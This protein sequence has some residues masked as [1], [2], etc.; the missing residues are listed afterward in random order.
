[1]ADSKISAL[2]A[3]S[4][5]TGADIPIVQSGANKKAGIALFTPAAIGAA[6]AAQGTKADSALQPADLYPAISTANISSGALATPRDGKRYV[7]QLSADVTDWT[8][9]LPSGGD[10]ETSTYWCVVDFTPPA[11]GTYTAAIPAAWLN[12][13]P[14]T[15]IV[16]SST[17]KRIRVHLSST[18]DELVTISAAQVI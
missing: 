16:L 2:T 6:T 11:S 15:S 1:M 13:G 10:A 12:L 5:L 18:S 8:A 9:A 4:D 3:A 7:C 17:S 14:L